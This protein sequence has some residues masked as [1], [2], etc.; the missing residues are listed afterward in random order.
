MSDDN[1]D[2]AVV[3]GGVSGVYTAW[4][5]LT[6]SDP[7]P[8]TVQVFE[9]SGRIGGRLLSLSPPDL[10]DIVCELGGMRVI[11]NQTRV[12]SLVQELDLATEPFSVGEDENIN[13]MRGEYFRTKDINAG[14]K[15]PYSLGWSESGVP[16]GELLGNI[17]D[18][19]IPGVTNLSGSALHKYLRH[20][21]VDGRPIHEWGFWNLL[22]RGMSHEA[23]ELARVISGYDTAGL[24]WNA[25]DTIALNFDLAAG[26]TYHRLP[27]GYDEVPQ[28]VAKRFTAAGGTINYGRRLVRLEHA[29]GDAPVALHFDDG[30]GG[31]P[32]TVNARHVI[33]AMP[34][35]SLELIDSAI[36]HEAR[37]LIRAVIPIPLFK[38]FVA[39]EFPWWESVGVT[40]G[41][42]VTDLPVRQCYYW[43]TARSQ[44]KEH[45]GDT[46]GVLLAS[47]DDSLNVDFWAGLAGPTPSAHVGSETWE[48]YAPPQAMVDEVD[49]QLREM[50]NVRYAP[51]AYTAAYMDWGVDPFG[52]GVNFWAVGRKSWEVIPRIVQPVASAPVYICGEAYSNGQGWVEGALETAEMVLQD[53]FHLAPPAWMG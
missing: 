13:Y 47:Y 16:I 10:P 45:H 20:A 14:C 44:S 1:L 39:Y 12:C 15:L 21:E 6:D 34:R 31:D 50:H 51:K 3:G 41:R 43:G 11:S 27:G 26:V 48:D 19:L 42:S 32:R 9:M 7:P 52:G 37:E 28:Q 49:R 4:R 36:L 24:N 25:Y 8:G 38:L 30:S 46:H 17:L 40:T 33:L 18:R 5:L 29:G 2:V 23:Y 22:A 53:H 35:R